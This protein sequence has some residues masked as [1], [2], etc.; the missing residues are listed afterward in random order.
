MNR[1][2]K[3]EEG[4]TLMEVIIVIAIL[5]ILAAVAIPT[6]TGYIEKARQ[7]ADLQT[8]SNIIRAAQVAMA[9]PQSGVPSDTLVEILWNTGPETAPASRL[10]TILMR[11]PLEGGRNSVLKSEPGVKCLGRNDQTEAQKEHFNKMLLETLRVEAEEYT[12]WGA[13]GYIGKL[14]EAKSKVGQSTSFVVHLNSTTGEVALASYRTAKDSNVWIDEIGVGD[15]VL[16][17]P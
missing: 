14:G 16:R 1:D 2:I 17:A 7:T 15:F 5:A 9:D 12:D 8:A 6:I 13:R 11:Y 10:G 4:F 3:K